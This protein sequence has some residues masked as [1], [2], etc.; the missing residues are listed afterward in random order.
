M[1]VTVCAAQGSAPRDPGAKMVVTDDD[2]FGSIGGGAL[3]LEAT[4]RARALLD[5]PQPGIVF[6]DYPLGPAL[7]QCCGG[8]V[9]VGF[10]LL[11]KDD[12]DWLTEAAKTIS[13]GGAVIL[14]TALRNSPDKES[15][16]RLF[17]IKSDE[18]APSVCFL[19]ADG[20]PFADAMPPLEACAALRERLADERPQVY[21]FGAGHVGCAMAHIL[22]TL[23][24]NTIWIDRREDQ[25]PNECGAGVVIDCTDLETE[26]VKAAPAGASYFVLT[27]SHQLDYDLVKAI[28]ERDD[29]AYCGLIGSKTK[30]ARFEQR[31]RRAGLDEEKIGVLV[32]PIGGGGLQNKAPGVIAIAA[33]HEMLLACEARLKEN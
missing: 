25:F 1:V 20:A 21:L 8:H 22:E 17:P 15:A 31:L 28:L 29:A 10:D 3:E 14:E 6:E 33:I 12:A 2:Q 13:E 26:R 9:R 4:L 18:D 23:P 7:G 30:R 11:T 24:V 19:D 27:H 32:C 5:N 16:R